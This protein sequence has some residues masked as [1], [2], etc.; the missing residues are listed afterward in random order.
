MP[1]LT[2]QETSIMGTWDTGSFDNDTAVDW[3]YGLEK[4]NDLSIIELAFDRV[5]GTGAS[6]G[7]RADLGE[8]AVAAA[9]APVATSKNCR[10]SRWT[11]NSGRVS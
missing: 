8:E 11:F 3:S 5:L 7:V 4:S 9:D 1:K 10:R 2:T 6:T